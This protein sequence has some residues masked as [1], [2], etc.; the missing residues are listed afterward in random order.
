LLR[1]YSLSKSGYYSFL[2]NNPA[3]EEKDLKTFSKILS[4]YQKNKG[5]YGYRRLTMALK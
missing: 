4:I 3:K 2:K 5:K 1:H